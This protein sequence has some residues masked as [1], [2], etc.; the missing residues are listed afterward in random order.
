MGLKLIHSRVRNNEEL[1]IVYWVDSVATWNS[2]TMGISTQP[3]TM[4]KNE[5]HNRHRAS[6][7]TESHKMRIFLGIL[8][9]RAD[10]TTTSNSL[11][12]SLFRRINRA[13]SQI[14]P[15]SS[16]H[17]YQQSSSLSE[18]ASMAICSG[19]EPYSRSSS[20]SQS[21]SRSSI[22]LSDRQGLSSRA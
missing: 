19:L 21:A 3:M 12:I 11:L 17:S 4:Q 5:K 1:S 22:I 16:S 10:S 9:K 18:D 15:T 8:V 7:V 13:N 2:T 14:L 20:L 6:P